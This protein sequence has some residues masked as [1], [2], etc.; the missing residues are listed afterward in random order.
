[1]ATLKEQALALGDKLVSKE[2]KRTALS[3]WGKIKVGLCDGKEPTEEALRHFDAA[4]LKGAGVTV[5]FAKAWAK[6]FS[7]A[8]D[9][10]AMFVAANV[11]KY[12]GV[13]LATFYAANQNDAALNLEIDNRTKGNEWVIAIEGKVYPEQS[14][15]FIDWLAADDEPPRAIKVDGK[16]VPPVKRGAERVGKKHREDP[17]APGERLPVD[18]VSKVTRCNFDGVSPR[19]C[20]LFRVAL[21]YELRGEGEMAKRDMARRMVG[22]SPEDL[23]DVMP[24]AYEAFEK[25]LEK[26]TLP[27]LLLSDQPTPTGPSVQ[28]RDGLP[29]HPPPRAIPPTFP[30]AGGEREIPTGHVYIPTEEQLR[31]V[32]DVLLRL[33]SDRETYL[34]GIDPYVSSGIRTASNHA[35][36]LMIDLNTLRSVG[37]TLSEQVPIRQYIANA[38]RCAGPRAEAL[39][40]KAALAPRAIKTVYVVGAEHAPDALAKLKEHLILAVRTGVLRIIDAPDFG[41]DRATHRR[42][43]LGTANIIL[44]LVTAASLTDVLDLVGDRRLIPILVGSSVWKQTDLANLTP[45]PRDGRPI[46]TLPSHMQ[47]QAYSSIA[48]DVMLRAKAG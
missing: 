13:H 8:M 30:P 27:D 35:D 18:L 42:Y 5:V 46:S 32:Y 22:L 1:M 6:L 28:Y 4:D 24:D 26:N 44:G 31:E 29:P 41:E 38:L 17:S 10:D 25:M 7:G 40:L 36:Q 15:Q 33:D 21:S 37:Q 45:L 16:K 3:E 2:G 23:S 20:Q 39:T 11:S 14:G 12:K 19:C 48:M 47:D 34:L 43:H 9:D